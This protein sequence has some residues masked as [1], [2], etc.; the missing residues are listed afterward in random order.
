MG[1]AGM[2]P[3]SRPDDEDD[4]QHGAS[5]PLSDLQYSHSLPQNK[6]A[7]G[8]PAAFEISQTEYERP[9]LVVVLLLAADGLQL[10]EH[11][12]DVEIVALLFAGFEFRLF[13]GGLGG[14]QQGGAAVGRGDR[15]FLG[16]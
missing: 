7:A 5:A 2:G 12:V 10:G 6:N 4:G 8:C 16:V 9:L 3:G 13:L 1:A 14:R 11:G 15:L